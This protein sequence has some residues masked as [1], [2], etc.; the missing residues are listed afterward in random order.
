MATG[1]L[2]PAPDRGPGADPRPPFDTPAGHVEMN[3]L[4]MYNS[5]WTTRKRTTRNGQLEKNNSKWTTRNG[6]LAQI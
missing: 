6:Q 1:G 5:K 4:E 3:K 2:G